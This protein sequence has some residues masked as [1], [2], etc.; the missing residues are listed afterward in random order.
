MEADRGLNDGVIE[1]AQRIWSGTPDILKGFMA[2]PELTSVK[3]I[4][5][6]P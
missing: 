5:G 6:D 3:L 4:Y 2:F 1:K